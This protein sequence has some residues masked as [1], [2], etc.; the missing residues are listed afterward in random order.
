M[1]FDWK[2]DEKRNRIQ[3]GK[4]FV[5][6]YPKKRSS[7]RYVELFVDIR[8]IVNEQTLCN[9]SSC[10]T[11]RENEIFHLATEHRGDVTPLLEI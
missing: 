11:R 6:R 9:C 3:E 7:L 5:T 1:K 8:Q 2:G 10:V 4:S